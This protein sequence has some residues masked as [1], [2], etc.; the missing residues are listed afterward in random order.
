MFFEDEFHLCGSQGAD[1]CKDVCICDAMYDLLPFAQFKNVKNTDGGVILLVKLQT[2]AF[3]LPE[4]CFK[5][6]L[7]KG[8]DDVHP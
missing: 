7:R 5:F 1:L 3:V 2:S 6:L 8:N 4:A